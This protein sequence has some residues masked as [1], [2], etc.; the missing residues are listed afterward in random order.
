MGANISLIFYNHK[1]QHMTEHK[2]NND[3]VDLIGELAKVPLQH[4]VHRDYPGAEKVY[5]IPESLMDKVLM[6]LKGVY[7]ASEFEYTKK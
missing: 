7:V 6:L 1:G 3:V 5:P 4:D 2:F